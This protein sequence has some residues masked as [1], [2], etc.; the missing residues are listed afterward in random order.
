MD[1]T[2]IWEDCINKLEDLSFNI[3]DLSDVVLPKLPLSKDTLCGPLVLSAMNDIQAIENRLQ[4]GKL[5]AIDYSVD[6][7]L[8]FAFQRG[9]LK[10]GDDE[11][12]NLL[13][14]ISFILDELQMD[15]VLFYRRSHAK[16]SILSPNRNVEGLR[17]RVCEL[18]SSVAESSASPEQ[19]MKAI[20][21]YCDKTNPQLL[22]RSQYTPEEIGT[23][24]KYDKLCESLYHNKKIMMVQRLDV[25][26]QSLLWNQPQKYDTSKVE[27]LRNEIDITHAFSVDQVFESRQ[28]LLSRVFKVSTA[29]YKNK[30]SFRSMRIAAVPDRGGRVVMDIPCPTKSVAAPLSKPT[31]TAPMRV[32]SAQS[33]AIAK[34]SQN[35][36]EFNEAQKVVA[37]F[38]SAM[39]EQQKVTVSNTSKKVCWD[40][41]KGH[42]KYGDLCKYAHV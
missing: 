21:N 29:A 9:F 34:E 11:Q 8:Q 16:Q 31:S 18:A 23:L 33:D 32:G 35:P 1:R 30:G 26:I 6:D 12:L 41:R 36:K 28:T 38:G 4:G 14:A 42:C 39:N 5:M 2:G 17:Q 20:Y 37:V 40:Y 22:D 10:S 7:Y 27:E 3:D 19:A 25:T 13:L 24:E 15:R